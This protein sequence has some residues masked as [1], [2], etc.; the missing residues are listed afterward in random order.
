[1][2]G[3]RISSTPLSGPT[4]PRLFW[5][6]ISLLSQV[7]VKS[8]GVAVAQGSEWIGGYEGGGKGGEEGGAE[9]GAEG[10]VEG[11]ADGEGGTEG[12]EEGG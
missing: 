11:G 2:E 12:G 9:G 7:A 3:K 8:S 4:P 10:G 6:F 1:M 5:P